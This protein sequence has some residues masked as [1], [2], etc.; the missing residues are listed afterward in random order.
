MA[1]V[2]P[3]GP[4]PGL[5]PTPPPHPDLAPSRQLPTSRRSGHPNQYWEPQVWTVMPPPRS[6]WLERVRGP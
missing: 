6:P 5:G 1:P 2:A 4:A 3:A